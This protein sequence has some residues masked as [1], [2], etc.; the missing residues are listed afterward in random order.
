MNRRFFLAAAGASGAS[1]YETTQKKS[2][3]LIELRYYKLRNTTDDMPKRLN[4]FLSGKYLPALRKSGVT[5]VGFF[6]NLIG[7]AS[8]LVLQVTEFKNLAQAEASWEIPAALDYVRVETSLIRSFDGLP[9]LEMPAAEA[10]RPARVFELRTYESNNFGSLGKKIGMFNTGEIA[11]FRKTGL[12]PVFF[13]ET[14]F[15]ANMPNLT[16]MLWY[17]SLAAREANW[18]KF[19][20]HPDWDKLKSTPG[21]SDGEVVSNISNSMLT[22]LAYSPIR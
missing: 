20:G 11:I 10:G 1:A 18:K 3:S 7:Q 9:S 13:G 12:N 22:P 15:G 19:V 2:N 8:P 5:K 17:D 16:Y 4:E 14:V 6:G 21:L